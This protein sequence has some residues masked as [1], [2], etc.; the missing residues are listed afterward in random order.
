MSTIEFHPDESV[1]LDYA[2]GA[3]PHGASVV[4]ACHLTL[5]GTCRAKVR[6]FEVLGGALF[7]ADFDQA[8]PLASTE[9]SIPGAADSEAQA[10][11]TVPAG[12]EDVW[13]AL[14]RPAQR[15]LAVSGKDSWSGFYPGMREVELA[16]ESGDE[17]TLYRLQPG[18]AMPRHRHE[19]EEMTLVLSGG[20]SDVSGSYG[21]GDV[22]CADN[23]VTHRPVADP[24]EPCVCIASVT[25]KVRLTGLMGALARLFPDR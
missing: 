1:L 14:P 23:T 15:M 13:E 20:F 12:F 6:E 7:A 10:A 9:M 19:G 22:A 17:L 4:I 16:S 18:T 21:P 5:C 3:L 24:G 11:I 25:G 2:T 8:A